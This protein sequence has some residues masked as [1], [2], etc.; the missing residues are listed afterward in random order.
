M[1]SSTKERSVPRT[2]N[3]SQMRTEPCRDTGKSV[4]EHFREYGR[5]RPGVVALW[6]LGIGF[7]LGW[8][9]KLW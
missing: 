2:Q 8:K 6:C 9:L 5:E 4:F 7:T 1:T 3:E